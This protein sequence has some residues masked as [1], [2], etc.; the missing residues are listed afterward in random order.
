Q[1]TPRGGENCLLASGM[2]AVSLN[3]PLAFRSL[4]F[5]TGSL[6]LS[7]PSQR[8]PAETVRLGRTNHWSWRKRAV[9]FCPKLARPAWAEVRPPRPP[10]CRYC[11][12][13]PA[14]K[15]AGLV[16]MKTP[17]QL[18]LKIWSVEGPV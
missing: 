16:K 13:L 5:R 2:W 12:H 15:S 6:G 8:R 9:S 18:P 11:D 17:R 10:N 7:S 1:E 3:E 14:R 4:E